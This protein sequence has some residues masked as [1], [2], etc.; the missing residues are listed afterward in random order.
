MKRKTHG[1][2]TPLSKTHPAIA[3]EAFG[4]DPATLTPGSNRKVQW[5]CRKKHVWEQ[6]VDSRTQGGSSCPYCSN[7][8]L[9]S[10][11]NDLATLHP[12]LAKEAHGWNPKMELPR[13]KKKLEWQCPRGHI[14]RSSA[15]LR[16]TRK[17]TCPICSGKKSLAG[18]NDLATTHPSIASEA[19]GWDPTKVRPGNNNKVGWKCRKGHRWQMAIVDRTSGKQGCPVCAGRRVL[20]G[21]NDLAT[22]HPEVAAEADGWDP[23]TVTK[24]SNKKLTWRCNNSHSWSATPGS[25]TRGRGCPVCSGNVV[26]AG[27]ND[28]ATKKPDLAKQAYRWDPRTVTEFSTK[29]VRWRCEKQ[30]VWT[31]AVSNRSAGDTGCPFCAGQELLVGYNDLATTHPHLASQAHGWDPTVERASRHKKM[32]WLGGCGHTWT[33]PISARA[34]G[35]FGCPFCSGKRVL[36]GFNDL[37]TTHPEVAAEADGWN[38]QTVTNG[39]GS[40]KQWKCSLGHRWKATVAMRVDRGTK[41]GT[42]C[43]YCAGNKVLVGFNDLATTHPDIASQAHEWDPRSVSQGAHAR[44]KWQCSESHIWT[45]AVNVRVSGTGC[46]TCARGGFDPNENG[47]LYFLEHEEWSLYQ[48]GITNYPKDRLADHE[49]LGWHVLELRGPMDGH[50]TRDLETAILQYVRQQGA[51][52]ANRTTLA[53][54][55]GWTEAWDKQSLPVSGLRALIDA[56]IAI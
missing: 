51:V 56:A 32:Q 16:I 49:S 10:G 21:F 19:D 37:V 34:Y 48:V 33:A 13:G 35:G 8:K 55:D 29:K 18:F 43:P 39:S 15:Y 28:L 11:F 5:Q 3:R 17:S 30:H 27:F 9:L 44:K 50:T 41:R 36:A 47:W 22:T 24:G 14:W 25:R 1:G 45:A 54:F 46:P 53:K 23:S 38:P 40:R 52:M 2:R 26:Q 12:K 42:S 20:R 7:N 6:T 4:W 31:A